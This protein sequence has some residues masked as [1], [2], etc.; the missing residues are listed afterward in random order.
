MEMNRINVGGA[1]KSS[2]APAALKVS[3]F[4]VVFRFNCFF[5]EFRLNFFALSRLK[6]QFGDQNPVH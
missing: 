2:K 1:A 6:S 3:R 4:L 5:V